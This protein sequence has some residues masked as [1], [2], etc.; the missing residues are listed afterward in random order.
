MLYQYNTSTLSH[1]AQDGLPS[2]TS[3]VTLSK[4]SSCDK[5]GYWSLPRPRCEPSWP[6]MDVH[7]LEHHRIP[8]SKHAAPQL[9]LRYLLESHL[10][11]LL[12]PQSLIACL[13]RIHQPI[14]TRCCRTVLC[15]DH[16]FWPLEP[17][18]TQRGPSPSGPRRLQASDALVL[19]W[20]TWQWY[21]LGHSSRGPPVC[22]APVAHEDLSGPA[23]WSSA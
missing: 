6:R 20:A 13:D 10:E 14:A 23:P 19:A 15:R 12:F 4:W 2:S 9:T 7:A 21:L 5:P 22:L 1:G 17:V 11:Y 8:C 18:P 3:W 16:P